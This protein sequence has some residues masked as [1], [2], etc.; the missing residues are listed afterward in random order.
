MKII[1]YVS[2][3]TDLDGNVIEPLMTKIL[4]V[5]ESVKYDEHGEALVDGLMIYSPAHDVA[6]GE[7]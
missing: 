5:P 6:A 2:M 1:S 7:A 3:T 4:E